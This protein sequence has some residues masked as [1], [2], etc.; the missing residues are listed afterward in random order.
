MNLL[1][2]VEGN[3]KIFIPNPKDYVKEGKFDPS[4]APV[5]YNPKMEFNRSISVVA[6]SIIN[7]KSI[8]DAL[9]ATGVRG[10]RYFMESKANIEELILN[11]KNPIAIDLIKRNL[12]ANNIKNGKLYNRDAN[13][14]LYEI[15]SDFVDIDPFG[16]P[17]P[18]ILSSINSSKRKGVV[19]Y[20]ATDLS[21][22]QGS[23]KNSCRRKYDSEVDK[24]SFSRE[25]GI[26]VLIGKIAREAS[27]LEKSIY[28]LFAFFKDYYYRLFVRVDS[29]AKKSDAVLNDLGY[30]FECESCGYFFS[31]KERCVNSCPRCGSRKL[32]TAGPLWLGSLN[33]AEFLSSM[34]SQL[35]RFDYLRSFKEITKL[36]DSLILETKYPLIGYYRLDSLASKLKVNIPP[37]DKII[38]CLRGNAVVSHLDYRGIKTDRN[39]DEVIECIKSLSNINNK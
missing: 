23:S 26:R 4:W 29:G 15:K 18:F 2:I 19:A 21:P 31:S 6:V 39:F 3:A 12:D 13:A 16:S 38:E 11:D 30:I 14:L 22:L 34:K 1:Q 17:A 10:I 24:L 5:F 32:R 7:P 20:T 35:V 27:I 9:A 8:I 37:R 28:P 33:D 25:V 36:L